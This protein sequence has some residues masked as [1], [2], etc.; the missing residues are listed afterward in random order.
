MIEVEEESSNEL[1]PSESE[2]KNPKGFKITPAYMELKLKECN[3]IDGVKL[4]LLQAPGYTVRTYRGMDRVWWLAVRSVYRK[5][6][7]L[8]LC[9]A[10]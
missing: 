3:Y 4:S 7:N 2:L 8:G 1:I 5:G 6:W 10:N 9:Q